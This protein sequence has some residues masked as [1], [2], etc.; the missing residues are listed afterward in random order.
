MNM[1]SGLNDVRSP[2]V[3]NCCLNEND[4][5]LGCHRTHQE[6][7]AWHKMNYSDKTAHL[8]DLA[9]RARMVKKPV[10]LSE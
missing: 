6:I 8:A 2:C 7:L 4:V 1:P 9:E 10:F 3:A 5:C